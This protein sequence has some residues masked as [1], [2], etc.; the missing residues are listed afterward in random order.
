M[1]ANITIIRVFPR[2]KKLPDDVVDEFATIAWQMPGPWPG[3]LERLSASLA[4]AGHP[5]CHVIF[6]MKD[7]DYPMCW[8]SVRYTGIDATSQAQAAHCSRDRPGRP[9]NQRVKEHELRQR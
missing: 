4:L 7:F 8:I 5:D 9:I 1:V 6:S 3:V 2:N